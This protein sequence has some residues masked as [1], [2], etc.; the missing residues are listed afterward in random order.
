H[1]PQRHIAARLN[2]IDLRVFSGGDRLTTGRPH[3]SEGAFEFSHGGALNFN[4]GVSPLRHT[5]ASGAA[6]HSSPAQNPHETATTLHT[7][8]FAMIAS[9]PIEG[10]E[11]AEGIV[12]ARTI[13]TPHLDSGFAQTS[14][15][16][17]GRRVEGA[18]PVVNQPYA[19]AVARFLAE[20]VGE[21]LTL[22]VFMNDVAF[23]MDC[24]PGRLD[25]L[26][27]G[28]VIFIGVFEDAHGVAG[29]QSGSGGAQER[30]FGEDA[31]GGRRSAPAPT[32]FQL[33]LGMALHLAG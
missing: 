9:Q 17:V 29:N 15:E 23:K 24:P 11:R 2:G 5:R 33:W 7:Y 28:G 20:R 22:L 19:Y 12:E 30:L 13:E 4:S 18:Y 6:P 27:P 10:A 3:L 32:R 14:P 21:D 26:E 25:R 31:H 1:N 8:E 16:L